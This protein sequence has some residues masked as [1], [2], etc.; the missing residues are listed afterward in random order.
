M[1]RIDS[2]LRLRL[3]L[4]FG[5]EWGRTSQGGHWMA[6]VWHAVVCACERESGVKRVST[7]WNLAAG[8]MCQAGGLAGVEVQRGWHLQRGEVS[9][10]KAAQVVCNTRLIILVSTNKVQHIGSCV[11]TKT[12]Y[13]FAQTPFRLLPFLTLP[14]FSLLFRDRHSRRFS[15]ASCIIW[16]SLWS[17][18]PA[19]TIHF[20]DMCS[21]TL[22]LP[23]SLLCSVSFL[24]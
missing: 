21:L 22:L 15:S 24:F 20:R 17:S 13:P 2:F 12:V 23:S 6:R 14:P 3:G 16:S 10:K 9:R 8:V 1:S 11:A 5:R 18:E 4:R 19:G 7:N